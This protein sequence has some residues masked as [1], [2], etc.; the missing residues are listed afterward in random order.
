MRLDAAQTGLVRL[1]SHHAQR[2]EIFSLH[3]SNRMCAAAACMAGV[4]SLDRHKAE[5]ADV[6]RR[7]GPEIVASRSEPTYEDTGDIA[8][9]KPART[10]WGDHWSNPEPC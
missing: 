9:A 8:L 5:N 2:Q 7:S 3:M 10:I 6:L 4:H 1:A